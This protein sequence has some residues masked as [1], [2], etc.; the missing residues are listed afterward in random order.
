FLVSPVSGQLKYFSEPPPSVL[1]TEKPPW[2]PY[3]ATYSINADT[4]NERFEYSVQKSPGVFRIVT[5]GD[6]FTFGQN[7]QTKDNW[8]ELLEDTLKLT[9]GKSQYVE[10]IN[11]GERGYDVAYAAHR[12]EIRG[13]KY[14]P[15][16]IIYF[17]SGT[18]FDRIRE[19]YDP[20]VARYLQS[21]REGHETE[22]ISDEVFNRAWRM[23]T[24][25][26]Q[27]TYTHE[28]LSE[29][30]H[31]AWT[32]LF[33]VRR[34]TPVMIV[35]FRDL[36]PLNLAKLYAWTMNQPYL[37]VFPGVR[38]LDDHEGR[39]YDGHPSIHGHVIMAD[40]I[41]HNMVDHQL[42]PCV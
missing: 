30:V 36:P 3:T 40:D 24:E 2:L 20:L 34:N 37:T 8:T 7:V 19:L 9:C 28:Q 18:G 27:R 22:G 38:A 25:E 12:L 31:G 15:D 32:R 42:I 10:I 5:L 6:S 33:S 29:I 14:D 1:Q 35:A 11:L 26:L 17:E 23:A 39:L 21:Q 4:L 13:M 16:L 41:Y